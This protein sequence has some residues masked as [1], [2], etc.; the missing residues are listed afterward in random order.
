MIDKI[1][2]MVY[3][4]MN[5]IGWILCS[6]SFIGIVFIIIATPYLGC[7]YV[8]E[9]SVKNSIIVTVAIWVFVGVVYV[10]D[11]AYVRGRDLKQK[12]NKEQY[13][14]WRN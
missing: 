4:A 9:I 7:R 13:Y 11:A 6:L 2:Y 14:D 12:S 1:C 5:L 8:C 3:K 10:V